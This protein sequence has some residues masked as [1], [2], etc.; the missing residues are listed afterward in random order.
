MLCDEPTGAL[1]YVTGKQV[2]K[3][4]QQTCKTSRKTVIVITHNL[5]ICPMGDKVIRVKSGRIDSIEINEHP[6]DVE[7]IE[8]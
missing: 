4:L 5:A 8:Y 2:L 1:D 3:L 7:E 6:M